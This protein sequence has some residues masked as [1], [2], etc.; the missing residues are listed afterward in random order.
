MTVEIIN[1]SNKP[2]TDELRDILEQYATYHIFEE[3]R[4]RVNIK[5]NVITYDV[6][7]IFLKVDEEH[8]AIWISDWYMYLE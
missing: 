5:T 3:Q 4:N 8:I 2:I 7:A 6:R 1:T